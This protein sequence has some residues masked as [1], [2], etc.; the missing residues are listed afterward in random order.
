MTLNR[1]RKIFIF[2]GVCVKFNKKSRSF[3]LKNLQGRELI[4]INLL[5]D[6]PFLIRIENM[7]G[8][9]FDKKIRKG[10]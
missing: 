7:K 9:D 4:E 6:S 8:Y 10:S 3:T 5:V 2:T 1:F